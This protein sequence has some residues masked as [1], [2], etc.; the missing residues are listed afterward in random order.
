MDAFQNS[1]IIT[2]NILQKCE[3][4]G[5]FFNSIFNFMKIFFPNE[6]MQAFH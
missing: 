1:F 2:L 5:I 3:G 4:N 6:T